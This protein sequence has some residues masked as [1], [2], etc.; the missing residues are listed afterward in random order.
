MQITDQVRA[1]ADI[2][3]VVGS[4]VS[5]K[6]SGR[7][8]VG[9][10]PFHAEKSP[11]FSVNADKNLYYCFGCHVG[12][13]VFDFVMRH[14]GVDFQTALAT[15]GQKFGIEVQPLSAAQRQKQDTL[16]ALARLNAAACKFFSQALLHACGA[17]A[18]TYLTS[19]QIP[20]AFVKAR[21]LGFGHTSQKFFAYLQH[22][23]H[24]RE[25]AGLAGLLTQDG[26]RHLFEGR[27]IFPI[28]TLDGQ[29]AGFGARRLDDRAG[30]PKYI[31]SRDGL[32]FSKRRLLYGLFE[33]QGR[34]RQ[35]KRVVVVEGYTDVLA[36]H[37]SDVGE[38]VA[39]LGTAF[40]PE[41]AQA[42]GRLTKNTTLCLDA[43]AA[44][45]KAAFKSSAVL[46]QAGFQVS[47]ASLP[48]GEDPDSLLRRAG[49]GA[50]KTAVDRAR[51][52][53]EFFFDA[54]FA[55]D[56]PPGSMSIE[57]R[58]TAA[59]HLQPLL[60]ALGAGLEKDLYTERL[61]QRVGVSTDQL[62]RALRR[63][64]PPRRL[65]PSPGASDDGPAA[66]LDADAQ[67]PEQNATASGSDTME[68]SAAQNAPRPPRPLP[69]RYELELLRELLLYPQLRARFGEIAD[70]AVSPQ[71][72]TL[73]EDLAT[74][75]PLDSVLTRHID[76]ASWCRRL[77]AIKPLQSEGDL[78]QS[79][80]TFAAVLADLKRRHLHA[81]LQELYSE[82]R[83]GE[84]RGE[85]TDALMR[86]KQ[87]LS[88]RIR[89]LRQTTRPKSSSE[90]TPPS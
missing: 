54:A 85:A 41:H 86:R 51:P 11:S 64:Q 67:N 81:A 12:G 90:D 78:D 22:H 9:L 73:L 24:S 36:A 5:L 71:M 48:H 83:Q 84:A 60:Q 10:C 33:A 8:H 88:A 70:F 16:T 7:N 34:I 4:R 76:H 80:P 18:R 15:L 26:S 75:E 63:L 52:S 65:A 58:A 61:A 68:S 38:A 3:Q 59:R 39:V 72:Q 37:R 47:V 14:D 89:A 1:V 6:K 40:T 66:N 2:L 69:Q 87:E 79:I 35:H 44:G 25:H 50:L 74:E 45:S 53:L 32:L 17:A 57:D 28:R 42:L 43:D 56:S 20:A 21:S 30:G 77:L 19:R 23:G 55:A 49:A 29:V 82:I 27:L 46:T 31:N 13:D 62:Q